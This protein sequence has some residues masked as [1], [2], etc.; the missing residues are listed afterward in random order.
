[1]SP[2]PPRDA[3]VT[4]EQRSL[5]DAL[6]ELPARAAHAAGRHIDPGVSRTPGEWS[7]REVLLHLI[8]VEIDV[9]QPRLRALE[10][11][12]FPSWPWVEPGLWNGPEGVTFAGALDVYGR[13]RGVTV[14]A[15]DSLDDAGWVRQGRHATFGVLDVAALMQIALDHDEEH[16]AQIRG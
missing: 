13:Q 7:A 10:A 1:M 8:A 4:P 15:L 11:E 9:W 16:L 2:E 6:A 14:A 3:V 5:R 12:A